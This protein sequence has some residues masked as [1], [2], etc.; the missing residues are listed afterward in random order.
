MMSRNRPQPAEVDL[1]C[2]PFTVSPSH[3]EVSAL[4]GPAERRQVTLEAGVR[5][6]LYPRRGTV[7]I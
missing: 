3:E 6:K 1:E 7:K 4:T 5:R 2:S